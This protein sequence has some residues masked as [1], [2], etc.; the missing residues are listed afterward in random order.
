V[1]AR[2]A[3]VREAQIGVAGA[4]DGHPVAHRQLGL[5]AIASVGLDEPAN[6]RTA[7]GGH[8]GR[9]VQGDVVELQMT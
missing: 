6:I 7:R 1:P 4:A 3:F 2:G 5:L 8:Q 9:V